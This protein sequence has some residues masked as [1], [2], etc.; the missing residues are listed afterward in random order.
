MAMRARNA[1]GRQACATV[2]RTLSTARAHVSTSAL[3]R[4]ASVRSALP[5]LGGGWA[6]RPLVGRMPGA[7]VRGMASGSKDYYKVLGVQSNATESEIKVAYRKMAM[8]HHPDRNQGDV[9][10][11]EKFKEISQAY[12]VLSDPGERKNYD[13]FGEGGGGQGFPG[14]G[15]EG[16]GEG[17]SPLSQEEAEQVF[18]AM[19]G[20]GG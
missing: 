1:L 10:A 20:Q 2:L 4:A 3:P 15:F 18:E 17:G 11:A 9:Q 8:Q 5:G 7:G 16:F 19:F 13:M 12:T 14:G 6:A